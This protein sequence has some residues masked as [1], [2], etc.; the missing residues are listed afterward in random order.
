MPYESMKFNALIFL[1]LLLAFSLEASIAGEFRPHFKLLP[2]LQKT[3]LLP[4]N[5]INRQSIKLV[6]SHDIATQPEPSTQRLNNKM[7]L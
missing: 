6:Y 7:V 4:G 5:R 2:Y 1:F 3:Q